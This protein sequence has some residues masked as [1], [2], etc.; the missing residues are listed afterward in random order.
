M[1]ISSYLNGCGDR[2]IISNK[3][4]VAIGD[5]NNVSY[6]VKIKIRI[7]IKIKIQI[8]IQIKNKNK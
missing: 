2:M 5:W 1:W 6:L 7:K 8:K 3:Y 4:W